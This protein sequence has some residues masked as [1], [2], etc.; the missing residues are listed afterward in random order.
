MFVVVKSVFA[1]RSMHRGTSTRASMRRRGAFTIAATAVVLLFISAMAHGPELVTHPEASPTAAGPLPPR[2]RRLVQFDDLLGRGFGGFPNAFYRDWW[3][4]L[5]P[6]TCFSVGLS[7]P[8]SL[9]QC[10]AFSTSF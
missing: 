2:L 4:P 6:T 5:Y 10:I 9:A 3:L 8:A 1:L 7:N